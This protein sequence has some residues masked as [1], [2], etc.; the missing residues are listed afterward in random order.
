NCCIGKGSESEQHS[1]KKH[2]FESCHL[3]LS[4]PAD[5]ADRLAFPNRTFKHREV[6][7]TQQERRQPCILV[8]GIDES[9]K[10]EKD[11]DAQTG[12]DYSID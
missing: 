10:R 4:D 5:L 7:A 11:Y 9:R 3:R 2:E 6:N 8:Q 12:N 1:Q